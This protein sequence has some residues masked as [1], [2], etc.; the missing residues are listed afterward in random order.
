M[1]PPRWS[2]FGSHSRGL[3]SRRLIRSFQRDEGWEITWNDTRRAGKAGSRNDAPYLAS[4][5]AYLSRRPQNLEE[6]R[7]YPSKWIRLL[8]HPTTIQQYSFGR[9]VLLIV[10]FHAGETIYKQLC[11]IF[12]IFN[13]PTRIVLGYEWNVEGNPTAAFYFSYGNE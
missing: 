3:F 1:C 12:N 11:E 13:K 6:E 10:L 2:F 5:R 8:I 4:I 7:H 9:C